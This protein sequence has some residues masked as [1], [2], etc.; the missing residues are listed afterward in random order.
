MPDHHR[1]QVTPVHVLPFPFCPK[2]HPVSVETTNI[3]SFVF[4][5]KQKQPSSLAGWRPLCPHKGR[6][7]RPFKQ[8]NIQT[9]KCQDYLFTETFILKGPIL[10]GKRSSMFF[11]I[12]GTLIFLNIYQFSQYNFWLLW[13]KHIQRKKSMTKLYKA[14][15]ETDPKLH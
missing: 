2:Y 6:S 1:I 9:R 3:Y 8:E 12:Y 4:F 7:L 15:V 11:R 5:F 14:L 13:I 10:C